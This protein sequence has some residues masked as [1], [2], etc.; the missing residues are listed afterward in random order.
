MILDRT[1]TDEPNWELP[2]EREELAL[3]ER[4]APPRDDEESPFDDEDEESPADDEEAEGFLPSPL[5]VAI[6]DER[7]CATGS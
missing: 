7:A 4:E 6:G 3:V 1:P 5:L 2:F